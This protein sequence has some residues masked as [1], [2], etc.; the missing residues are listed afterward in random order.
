[1]RLDVPVD[2]VEMKV[3]LDLPRAIADRKD[4]LA[5]LD[6]TIA[7]A[8]GISEASVEGRAL[9]ETKC[10]FVEGMAFSSHTFFAQENITR[11]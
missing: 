3:F 1:M 2:I 10:R 11:G 9:G 5:S 7:V 8:A 6:G 4:T